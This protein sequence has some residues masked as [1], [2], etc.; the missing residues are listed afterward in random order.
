MF[1][2][3]EGSS[4]ISILGVHSNSARAMHCQGR[5]ASE[6]TLTSTNWQTRA[7]VAPT[8]V[9]CVGHWAAVSAPARIDA[10]IRSIAHCTFDM[11]LAG[12]T[13]GGRTSD[14]PIG[15]GEEVL[16]WVH[17]VPIVRGPNPWTLDHWQQFGVCTEPKSLLEVAAKSVLPAC[18]P[19][20]RRPP[21]RAPRHVSHRAGA[22]SVRREHVLVR[23]RTAAH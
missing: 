7:T 6:Q 22:K 12:V 16:N 13:A 15:L 18:R 10:L 23:R 9:E 1:G 11:C 20:R 4:S 8:G 21:Q 3:K 14:R 5:I 19:A 2:I 17:R